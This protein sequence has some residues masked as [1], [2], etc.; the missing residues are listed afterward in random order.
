M[1]RQHVLAIPGLLCD[2]YVW[3]AQ[4]AALDGVADVVV[5]DGGDHD[6]LA[7]MAR[8]ALR[9]IDASA[10]DQVHVLGH[11][12][13]GRVALEVWRLAPDRVRSLVLLDTGVHAVAPDEP[14]RRQAML[15]L[16]AEGMDALADAWLPQMVHP[17]RRDDDAL[18]TQLREMVGRSDEVRHARQIAA[19][20]GRPDATP[21]LGTVTVPTLVVVGRDDEWS[22]VAQHEDI[23]RQIPGAVLEVVDDAGHFVTVEQPDAV[24]AL[25]VDWVTRHGGA[26]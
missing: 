24:S 1:T 18:M 5:A 3:R 6:D 23:V 2:E 20:L 10:D 9:L 15:D 22:P 26:R 14:E 8:A 16:A 25:L 12:M 4:V 7:D 13:G 21:L 11:S 17:D 19:L